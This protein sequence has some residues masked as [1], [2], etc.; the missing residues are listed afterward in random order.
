MEILFG[1]LSNSTKDQ[2]DLKKWIMRNQAVY[3]IWYF[4]FYLEILQLLRL[5]YYLHFRTIKVILSTT[6]Y[7][8]LLKM[9]KIKELLQHIY[10]P[11]GIS[12]TLLSEKDFKQSK[13][14]AFNSNGNQ[15]QNYEK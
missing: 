11:P 9:N 8:I 10:V 2:K 6:L 7:F 3:Q 13:T 12:N 1:K 15:K 5:K 14:K 4:K